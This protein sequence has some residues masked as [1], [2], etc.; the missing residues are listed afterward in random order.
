MNHREVMTLAVSATGNPY[1]MA[2]ME[3]P[4]DL[5]DEIMDAIDNGTMTMMQARDTIKARGFTNVSAMSLNRYYRLFCQFRGMYDLGNI[6]MCVQ[7]RY[8]TVDPVE[9]LRALFAVVSTMALKSFTD[10]S[11]KLGARDYATLIKTIGDMSNVV[12]KMV[13]DGHATLDAESK[14]KKIREVYGLT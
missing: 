7:E 5:Q 6:V 12:G 1:K 3:L 10:G 14:R 9:T 8:R 11:V 13:P 4:V 2:F